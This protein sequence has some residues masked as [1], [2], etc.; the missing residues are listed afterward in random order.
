MTDSIKTAFEIF[1]CQGLSGLYS[2][3][4]HV[5]KREINRCFLELKYNSKVVPSR[6]RSYEVQMSELIHIFDG[7]LS[8]DISGVK[9]Q[10]VLF[11]AVNGIN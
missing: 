10:Q 8:D 3:T 2:L 5:L 9:S 6:T 11:G 7:T 1:R 4:V